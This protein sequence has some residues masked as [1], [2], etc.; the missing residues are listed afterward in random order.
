MKATRFR[1]LLLV[2]TLALTVAPL[3]A[4]KGK[5]AD[6]AA[7]VKE[8]PAVEVKTAPVT[9]IEV[10]RTLRLT[11]TLRG[12]RETDLAANAS[13]RVLSTTVE[14][15]EQIKPGQ[16]LAKLDTRALAL[17]AADARAQA[18]SIRAQEQQAQGECERYEQLKARGAISDL[19]Y[20][21]KITQCRTL[22]LNVQAATA[23][24]A[25]AAQNVGDGVIRAP[26]A[27]V[28]TERYV[29]VGQYV[30]QDS[31]IVTIVSADPLRLQITVPESQVASVKEGANV[32]FAVAAYPE[33]RFEGKVRFV[34]GALRSTTRDL[35]A[36]AIVPNPDRLLIPGMFADVELTVGSQ[37]SASV[38]VAATREADEQTRVFVVTAG[39]LEERIVAVGPKV[40]DRIAIVR[41]VK[42]GEQV[43]VSDLTGLANGRKVR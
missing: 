1:S 24:A 31:R 17:S 40:G 27:G 10:P 16:V 22:P 43:V 19:E 5:T 26:F 7:G 14:R 25:L 30:R 4:C 39:R 3:T 38:P 18:E 36:E 21:Q 34:S 32:T 8:E 9:S 23:R 13:G 15:G 12:D 35:V 41:G 29:E 11:G 37:K 33:R 42:E 6:A 2:S 20:Q 28:V